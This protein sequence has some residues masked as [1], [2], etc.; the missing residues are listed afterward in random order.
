[1]AN[2]NKLFHILAT[3]LVVSSFGVDLYADGKVKTTYKNKYFR[4]ALDD[5]SSQG[6]LIYDSVGETY[7]RRLAL[8][9]TGKEVKLSLCTLP[10]YDIYKLR[11]RLLETYLSAEERS[12]ES[13]YKNRLFIDLESVQIVKDEQSKT[14]CYSINLTFPVERIHGTNGIRGVYILLSADLKKEF[15][16][17]SD[18]LPDL[19]KRIGLITQEGALKALNEYL[20]Q[21]ESI[22]AEEVHKKINELFSNVSNRDKSKYVLS[23]AEAL[24]HLDKKKYLEVAIELLKQ[25]SSHSKEDYQKSKKIIQDLNYSDQPVFKANSETYRLVGDHIREM[26]SIKEKELGIKKIQL[27]IDSLIQEIEILENPN[28]REQLSQSEIEAHLERLNS[29]LVEKQK[30]L[31]H[32]RKVM[33]QYQSPQSILEYI[34]EKDLSLSK[35][36]VFTIRDVLERM[37]ITE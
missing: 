33:I 14:L 6:Q 22:H 23:A 25:V 26:I 18:I 4:V 11:H 19:A 29:A 5:Y 8:V 32:L 1:M 12:E 10:G 21:S 35:I 27:E 7:L 31:T 37:G 28:L 13:P 30:K 15:P 20:K 17:V 24:I 2:Q 36:N 16:V 9:G 34:Q 3:L